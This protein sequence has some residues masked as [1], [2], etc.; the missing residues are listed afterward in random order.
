MSAKV[1]LSYD[2]EWQALDWAKKHCPSYITND[3]VLGKLTPTTKKISRWE[4]ND[5]IAYYFADE[6]DAVWFALRWT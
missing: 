6:K 3:L 4:T 1:I 5:S 2:P